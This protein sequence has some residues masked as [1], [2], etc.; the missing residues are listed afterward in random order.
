MPAA[1]TSVSA[2]RLSSRCHPHHTGER[3][4]TEDHDHCHGHSL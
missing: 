4:A 1:A 2:Q 3:A